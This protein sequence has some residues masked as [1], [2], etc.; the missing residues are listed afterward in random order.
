LIKS[1]NRFV[2]LAYEVIVVDNFSDPADFQQLE[3]YCDQQDAVRLIRN[4]VN[5]GFGAGN[6]L[7]CNYA[8]FP[9]LAFINNDV[10]LL[11]DS[12]L[13]LKQFM[14]QNTGAG[15]VTPQQVT[16]SGSLAR[17]FD[18]FHGIRRTIFGQWPLELF[19]DRSRS[20]SS[21]EFDGPFA[22]DFVQGCFM[23][24]RASDFYQCGGFDTNLFLYCE[25]MDIC[26]RLK[27]QG[28]GRYFYPHSKFQHES[29]GS[30][31]PGFAIKVEP[32]L[33]FLYVSRKHHSYFKYSILKYFLLLRFI[34]KGTTDPRYFRLAWDIFSDKI[35]QRSIK[36][37]Q[38][39]QTTD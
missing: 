24:F 21:K 39:E 3:A 35:L 38:Y 33:S 37:R 30:T 15:V 27:Q 23:F 7:G 4:K 17:S 34:L 6:M 32:R 1:L 5:S 26:Y 29:R 16:E 22:V 10:V 2:D 20:R 14:D 8:N 13:K 9:Y 18:Y 28:F 25:E 31:E 36:Q 19:I 11:E 12:L